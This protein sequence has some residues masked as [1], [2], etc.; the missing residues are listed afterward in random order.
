MYAITNE[1]EKWIKG[2]DII[3]PFVQA[4]EEI[5]ELDT[6][7][8]NTNTLLLKP[9]LQE[10]QKSCSIESKIPVKC[11]HNFYSPIGTIAS[12]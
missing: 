8:T 3:S 10:I 12:F 1:I 6:N 7:Q 4:V 11:S 5:I 2:Y 9:F